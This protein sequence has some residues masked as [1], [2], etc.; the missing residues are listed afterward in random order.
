L[1]LAEVLYDHHNCIW[2]RNFECFEQ[3]KAEADERSPCLYIKNQYSNLDKLNHLLVELLKIN[4]SKNKKF[5][6]VYA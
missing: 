6:R 1:I 4:L 5:T 3:E 2:D